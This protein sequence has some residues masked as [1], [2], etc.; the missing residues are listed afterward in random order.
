MK[1]ILKFCLSLLVA[2]MIFS[3]NDREEGDLIIGT[4]RI[5]IDSVKIAQDSMDVLTTQTIKTYSNYSGNCE[6]FYGYDYVHKNDL[7][8]EV[9]SYNFK[10]DAACTEIVTRASLIN[11]RPQQAGDYIFKFWNGLNSSG[12]DIW[13]EKT[14]TVQ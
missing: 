9:T 8:R 5:K 11:F 3:C 4:D 1:N 14:I 6:G 12:E 10:T 13:I 7:T 2:M